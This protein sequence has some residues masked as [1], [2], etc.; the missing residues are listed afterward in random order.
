MVILGS[1]NKIT[2][3]LMILASASPF[4]VRNYSNFTITF[5]TIWRFAGDFFKVL[6]K[7][8]MAATDQFFFW[9]GGGGG[10]KNAKKLFGQ[11]FLKFQHHI[12]SNMGICKWFFKDATKIQNGRQ[13][14]TPNFFVGAK[15]PKLKVGNYSNFT[16]TSATLWRC[17]SDF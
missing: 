14:S 16:I 7:F 11:F 3:F 8:K 1:Q 13:R 17:V 12:P 5:P 9:W 4:K 6:L 15:T 10:R 2:D